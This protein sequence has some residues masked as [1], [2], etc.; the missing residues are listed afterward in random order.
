MPDG[1]PPAGGWPVYVDFLAQPYAN[2][3]VFTSD[4]EAQC[5]NGWIDPDAGY[6]PPTPPECTTLLS[7]DTGCPRPKF[8]ADPNITEGEAACQVCIYELGNITALGNCSE[9]IPYLLRGT[10]VHKNE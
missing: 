2:T 9:E 5:G 10:Y 3:S 4:A 8:Q 7:A 6:G 1:T